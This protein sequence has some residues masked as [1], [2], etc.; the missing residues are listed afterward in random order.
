M[1]NLRMYQILKSP[2]LTEKSAIGADKNSQ[3][4]FKVASDATKTEIREAVETLFEVKVRSVKTLNV[5][6]KSKRFGSVLGKRNDT[7]KAIV[8]LAEGHDINFA[9]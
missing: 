1:S 8:C 7:K 4:V 5:K 2:L 9:E 6:G 3:H